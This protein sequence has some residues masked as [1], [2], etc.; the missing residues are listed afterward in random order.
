MNLNGKKILFLSANFFDYEKAIAKRL[1]DFGAEVDLYNER[2]SDSILSKGIIRVRRNLYQ[3]RINRYYRKISAETENKKYDFFLLIKGESVPFSFLKEFRVRNPEA[4]TIF[5]SYDAAVEYPKF[6]QLYSFFDSN[7]TFEPQDAIQYKIHFRPLFFLNHYLGTQ[8]SE[9]KNYDLS[10]IG[11][12]HSDRYIIGEKIKKSCEQLGLQTFFYYFAP[13]KT[14]FL[15]KKMFD[16]NLQQ[17]D[18]AEL[19]FKKLTHN[20]ISSIYASSFAV[21]DINKPFQKGLTMRTFEA[22][23]SEKKLVTTNEDILNYPFYHKENVTILDRKDPTLKSEFFQ[24]EFKKLDP[25]IL[26]KMSLDSWLECLFD[27]HQD[28]FWKVSNWKLD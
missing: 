11:T 25:E 9:K 24:T 10:F 13:G 6:T 3:T 4:K 21:L 26:E 14:A 7:F 19:T 1:S 15:L 28:D 23:A 18:P 16:K 8:E 12:A 5:Y 2:P 22:L 27:H 20:E 17:F